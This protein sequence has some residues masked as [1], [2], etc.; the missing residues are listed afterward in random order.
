MVDAITYVIAIFTVIGIAFIAISL[1]FFARVY[2]S[3]NV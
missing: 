3:G 2:P 1:I